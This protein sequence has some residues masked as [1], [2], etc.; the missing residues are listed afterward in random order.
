MGGERDERNGVKQGWVDVRG[1][2][3][4]RMQRDNVELR[5]KWKG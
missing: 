4:W 3:R 2:N 1:G 5:R